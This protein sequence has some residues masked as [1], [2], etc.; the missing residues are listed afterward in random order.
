MLE[1]NLGSDYIDIQ[2]EGYP[3]DGYSLATNRSC[4]FAM[5]QNIWLADYQ[6]PMAYTDPFRI[7]Q[8][9]GS[10]IYAADGMGTEVAEGTEGAIAAPYPDR[11]GVTH[12]Y[13]DLKLE[14]M[15]EEAAS[16]TVD[17]TKR[18]NELAKVEDWVVEDQTLVIPFMR[19]GMGYVASML[20]PFESQYAPFGASDSRYKY[21]W[22]YDKGIST[23]QYQQ[24]YEAWQKEREDKLA[25][26][27]AEGKVF[28]VDY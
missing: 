8:N 16:E 10:A 15:T 6:D 22:V 13:T 21:Q 17:M 19:S 14:G 24:A 9:R 27:S 18:Y 2:T 26:L 7:Y 23:E 5:M 20:M 12:Y 25:E 11:D 4:N 28:G 1:T 3:D